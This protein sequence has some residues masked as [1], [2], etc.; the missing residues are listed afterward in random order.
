MPRRLDDLFGEI[1]SFRALREAALRAVRG[2]RHK[3]GAAVFFANIEREVL[4]LERQLNAGTWRPGAYRTFEVQDP[5]PR[6]VSAAPFRDRV[7]QHALCAVI[8][9]LFERGFIDDSFANRVGKGTHRAVARY[10]QFRNRYRH[11]LRCDIYRYFPAI[12]HEILKRDLRRRIACAPTLR[13]ID[14]IID[15]SNPQEPVNRYFPGDDLFSPLARRRGLPIGNLTSQLFANI[16]LDG[17]DHYVKEVLR[18]PYLRYVDDFALFDDDRQVLDDWRCTLGRYLEGRRLVLHPRKT[19]IL[20]SGEPSAFLGLVVMSGNRRA[21]PE[22]NVR[23][24][25]NRLRSLRDRWRAGT[26]TQEEVEQRVGSWVA[27]AAHA[28]TWRLRRAIFRGGWFDPLY[29]K[30]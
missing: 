12:D 20:P 30:P 15:A 8:E 6:Q 26:V 23:R 29:Q 27:H 25:R 14:A 1:A 16:Y 28:D 7:V 4:R 3:P 24:F 19:V 17:L 9:P 13:V 10:E 21:L 2:K 11:V 18:A 22:E 5:K